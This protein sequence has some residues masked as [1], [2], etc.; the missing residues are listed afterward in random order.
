M[1]RSFPQRRPILFSVLLLLIILVTYFLAGAIVLLLKLPTLALTIIGDGVLA[2]VAIL[3]LSRLHWWHAAGFRLPANPSYLLFFTVPCLP[4]IL[5]IAFAI[6]YT[7]FGYPG[8]A[9]VLLFLAIALAVGFVEEAF[10]RGMMLR[11]LIVRGPWQAAIISSIFFGIAHLLNV[12]AGANLAYTLLQVVYALAI[13]LMYATLALRTQTILP[14]IALH[15]L[16]DF[17]GFIALNSTV[18]TAGVST[19]VFV[20]TAGEI[21]IYIAYSLVLMR[22]GKSRE[23]GL[24]PRLE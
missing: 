9:G 15:G 8:I 21:V 16:T 10:F 23:P 14:L 12:A 18:V 11:A 19:L 4:I 5:N 22:Q 20:V 1:Q 13:G 7:G 3:L 17:V 2:L 24:E 6:S